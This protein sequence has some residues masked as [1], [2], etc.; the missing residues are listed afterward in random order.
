MGHHH[1]GGAQLVDLLQQ[2]HDLQG[3][4]GVQIA[5]GL[6]GHDDLGIVHQGPGDGH[7][8]L[9]AAGELVGQPVPLVVQAH[10]LQYVGDALADLPGGSPHHPHDEGQVLLHRLFLDE[11]EVL[12]DDP[13]SPAHVGDLPGVDVV[14]IVAVDHEAAAGA[15]HLAGDELQDGGFARTGGTHQKDEF[16]VLDL[17]GDPF[18]GPGAVVVGFLY[19]DET[20]HFRNPHKIGMTAGACP[21][22][23]P[24][25]QD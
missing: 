19:I 6:V 14:E 24:K 20:Y 4:L 7:A 8:L 18:Q 17:H 23:L 3:A 12:K 25:T 15:G 1:D 9:L 11:A 16:P 13:Q 22:A 2:H 21:P 10:Q 5:G